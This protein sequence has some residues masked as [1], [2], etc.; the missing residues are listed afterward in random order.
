MKAWVGLT[1]EDS[2]V[3]EGVDSRGRGVN[4]RQGV[5]MA[6]MGSTAEPGS[7]MAHVGLMTT[8]CAGGRWQSQGQ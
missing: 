8:V 2:G 5:M 1:A 4:S 3:G 6:H 7:M